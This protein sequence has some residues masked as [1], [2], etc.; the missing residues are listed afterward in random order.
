[1]LRNA[2]VFTRHILG[3]CVFAVLVG[4]V[5]DSVSA[6][7]HEINLGHSKI[8]ESDHTLILGWDE[9][10]V[11]AVVEIAYLRGVFLMQNETLLRRLCWSRKL[12]LLEALDTYTRALSFVP[13]DVAG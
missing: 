7:V 2:S 1:M 3:L 10:T 4:F 5:N 8:A 9:S 12:R 11:P 6:F 13:A